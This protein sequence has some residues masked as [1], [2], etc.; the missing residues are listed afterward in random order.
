MPSLTCGRFRYLPVMGAIGTSFVLGFLIAKA[1]FSATHNS[2]IVQES[3]V[4]LAGSASEPTVPE[5]SS[6]SL[7]MELLGHERVLTSAERDHLLAHVMAR[8]TRTFQ[9]VDAGF[10]G[11][12]LAELLPLTDLPLAESEAQRHLADMALRLFVSGLHSGWS[13]RDAGGLIRHLQ[14][15]GKKDSPM[16]RATVLRSLHLVAGTDHKLFLSLLADF[17]GLGGVPDKEMRKL[18]WQARVYTEPEVVVRQISEVP[19]T[20]RQDLLRL[21]GNVLGQADPAKL[22]AMMGDGQ[23]PSH[24]N[25]TL[26]NSV[27]ARWPQTNLAG[28]REWFQKVAQLSEFPPERYGALVTQLAGTRPELALQLWES[29]PV[30]PARQQSLRQ[31][32][33]NYARSSPESVLEWLKNRAD[34]EERSLAMSVYVPHLVRSDPPA[35]LALLEQIDDKMDRFRATRNLLEEWSN[36][37][38][39]AIWNWF[40]Q[41]GHIKESELPQYVKPA[42]VM[43][44]WIEKDPQAAVDGFR[45]LGEGERASHLRAVVSQLVESH[46]DQAAQL[47]AENLAIDRAVEAVDVVVN[48]WSIDDPTATGNWIGSLPVGPWQDTAINTL[49]RTVDGYDLELAWNWASRLSDPASRATALGGLGERWLRQDPT[50]AR[51]AIERSELAPELRARLGRPPR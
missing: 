22:L 45:A 50:A 46:P 33:D 42:D 8:M 32:L 6:E 12:L 21:A 25:D 51:N 16:D 31:V 19:L 14:A 28:S 24:F 30:S 23:I 37:D 40:H 48:R 1:R 4:P 47:V 44:K 13:K 35:A 17:R 29:M 43:T 15:A 2:A 18:E 20:A 36:S 7:L 5:S 9:M 39:G 27:L 11:R 26:V 3:V 49:L 41:H 10:Y 38:P 34:S